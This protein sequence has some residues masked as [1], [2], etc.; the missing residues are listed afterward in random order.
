MPPSSPRFW[1]TSHR[2]ERR[3]GILTLLPPMPLWF[4]K[5]KR[6]TA[7]DLKRTRQVSRNVANLPSSGL[8]SCLL[9]RLLLWLSYSRSS[10]PFTSPLSNP[11]TI[12]VPAAETL[13][14][15]ASPHQRATQQTLIHPRVLQRVETVR[16][17]RRITGQRSLITIRSEVFVREFLLPDLNV[18]AILHFESQGF[19][20]RRTHSTTTLNLIRGHPL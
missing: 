12:S 17:S 10:Y 13:A 9:W 15:A 14:R 11:R 19:T 18:A 16:L 8:C 7:G 2:S 3:P 6:S 20:T 1:R 5:P 4:P